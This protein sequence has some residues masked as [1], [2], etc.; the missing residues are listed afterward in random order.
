[1][2]M[3]KQVKEYVMKQIRN[4]K[5]SSAVVGTTDDASSNDSSEMEPVETAKKCGHMC[6][7]WQKRRCCACSDTRPISK[8]SKYGCY[9]DGR[10]YMDGE[11]ENNGVFREAVYCFHCRK[12]AYHIYSLPGYE[13]YQPPKSILLEAVNMPLSGTTNTNRKK[14][15]KRRKRKRGR[16]KRFLFF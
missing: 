7:L 4:S 8:N 14:G 6:Q 12:H 16:K 1:M 9:V 11:D 15:R 10:G 2:Q 3:F 5:I 13:P